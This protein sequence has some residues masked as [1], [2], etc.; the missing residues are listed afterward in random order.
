[1][2]SYNPL[3]TDVIVNGFILSGYSDE[4][5]EIEYNSEDAITPHVGIKGEHSVTEVADKSG[6]LKVSL[7]NSATAPLVFLENLQKTGIEFTVMFI[8]RSTGTPMRMTS[9]GCRIRNNPNRSRGVEET[10]VEW[11]FEF[12]RLNPVTLV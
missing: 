8:D 5:I 1:M 2:P 9:D 3:K 11:R 4:D 6:T 7:K 10:F 12:P